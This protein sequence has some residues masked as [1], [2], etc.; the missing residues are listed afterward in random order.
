MTAARKDMLFIEGELSDVLRSHIAK[1]TDAVNAIPERQFLNTDDDTIAQHIASE[2]TIQPIELHEEAKAMEQEEVQLDVTGRF[3][4]GASEDERLVV[5]GLRVTVLIPF[6]GH[7]SLWTLRP[8]RRQGVAARGIVT[9]PGSQG[10]GYLE[11]VIQRPSTALAEEYKRALEEDL[12]SIRFYLAAQ[13]TQIDQANAELPKLA[14]EAVNERRQRLE[15]HAGVAEALKRSPGAPDVSA[16]PI[17]RKL[18]RPLPPPPEQQPEP[19]IR[20]DDYEHILSVVRHEG[21]SYEATPKTFAVHGEEEL[22]D[23]ILAH[24]NGHYRGEATAETFRGKGSTDITIEDKNRAAFVA[25]CKVW[26]GP[27]QLEKAVDQLLGYL[28]WRDCKAALIVF[29]KDVA[30]FTELQ[31][32]VPEVLRRHAKFSGQAKTREPGEW[33]FRFRS[34]EDEKRQITVHVFLFNLYLNG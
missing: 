8:N 28:T 19:G 14:L 22:R 16:I 21:R 11:I 30:G 29:N 33:R 20:D 27:G 15:K 7:A 2:M 24:L 12:Q 3:E 26:R 32:K 1:V 10:I 6:T 31:A 9:N 17:K 25:E 23:I 4:Y 34:A 18:L 5:P 13:K